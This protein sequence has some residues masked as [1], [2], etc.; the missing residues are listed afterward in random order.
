MHQSHRQQ[1]SK[2]CHPSAE[3]VVVVV[4]TP[5]LPWDGGTS[6]TVIQVYAVN[7]IEI[8]LRERWQSISNQS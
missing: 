4:V 3:N 6:R 7:P 8:T 1:V 2:A 5:H